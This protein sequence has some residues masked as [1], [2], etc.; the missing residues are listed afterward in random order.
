[1]GEYYSSLYILL[2]IFQKCYILYMP[3]LSDNSYFTNI[4]MYMMI[5]SLLRFPFFYNAGSI[6]DVQ[7]NWHAIIHFFSL[8]HN[9]SWSLEASNPCRFLCILVSWWN[10]NFE[11]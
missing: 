2:F 8:F 6:A 1:M 11:I 9:K 4:L 5:K 3:Q 10:N 7:A